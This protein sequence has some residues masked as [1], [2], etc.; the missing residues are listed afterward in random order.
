MPV[1]R[2]PTADPRVHEQ[3]A[4]SQHK[5]W[6]HKKGAVEDLQILYYRAQ[7]GCWLCRGGSYPFPGSFASCLNPVVPPLA[8]L[9]PLF[10]HSPVK[11]QKVASC[12]LL[13]SAWIFAATFPSWR[14]PHLLNWSERM[15]LIGYI[16]LVQHWLMG[17]E[18][19]FH[20]CNAITCHRLVQFHCSFVQRRCSCQAS[21]RHGVRWV[22]SS[23]TA[24]LDHL[25]GIARGM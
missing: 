13:R 11:D 14:L 2:R 10:S 8:M 12:W 21:G 1:L 18:K 17:Q 9:T 24:R 15:V 16:D 4:I 5:E 7:R 19:E 6:D 23:P 20:H 25:G 3:F 22:W